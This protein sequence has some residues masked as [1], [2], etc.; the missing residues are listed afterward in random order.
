V[1]LGDKFST[2]LEIAASCH[3]REAGMNSVL[4]ELVG[5][6]A[7]SLEL[8][9]N[10]LASKKRK[11]LNANANAEVTVIIRGPT[12][13][14]VLEYH[15]GK[16]ASLC[17]DAHTVICCRVTPRQKAQCVSIV[18]DAGHMTLAIG[19]GGNDV[20][21]I[22][23]AHVGVGIRGKEGL[24]AA[25]A[26]DYVLPVFRGLG[27]LMLV[28]GQYSYLRSAL[29]MQYSFYKSFVFCSMQILYG[30]HCTFI[31]LFYVSSPILY[32]R[33]NIHIL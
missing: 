10:M 17:M 25:R 28:H 30:K 20:A 27:P 24:Q 1:F 33:S 14:L 26:A 29:V 21:M 4:C 6:S 8:E 16:F 23:A 13:A 22:Q 12:L 3:L 31:Y 9:M 15:Q 5:T 2:A 32:F 7:S 19:D 11:A 18:R